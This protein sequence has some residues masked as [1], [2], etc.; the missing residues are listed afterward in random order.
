MRKTAQT[1]ESFEKF[2]YKQVA[3]GEGC[4]CAERIIDVHEFN[5]LARSSKR[6]GSLL[7][8][9]GAWRRFLRKAGLYSR[10]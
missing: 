10:D 9:K 2:Y 7:P 6:I 5:R 1:S 3:T 8:K 4:G